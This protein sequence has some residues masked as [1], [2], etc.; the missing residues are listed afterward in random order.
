[1]SKPQNEWVDFGKKSELFRDGRLVAEVGIN[2]WGDRWLWW[3]HPLGQDGQT[4][5]LAEAKAAVEKE[6]SK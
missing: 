4:K 6:V 3:L 1:M 5:T 2:F